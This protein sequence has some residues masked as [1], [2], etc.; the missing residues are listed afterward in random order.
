MRREG[1]IHVLD[2][3]VAR[4]LIER[5]FPSGESHYGLPC[6]LPEN[7]QGGADSRPSM[8]ISVDDSGVSFW[9]CHSC[10]FKATLIDGLNRLNNIHEG[11][12]SDVAEWARASGESAQKVPKL[13]VAKKYVPKD[14]S[15]EL[16]EILETEIPGKAMD[17]L[18][19]KGCK[20]SIANRYKIGWVT[21][22]DFEFHAGVKTLTDIMVF[23]VLTVINEK[24]M[25]VGAQARQIWREGGSKYFT[26]FPF[27]AGRHLFGEQFVSRMRGRDVFIMEGSLDVLYFAGEG[28]PALGALG[29]GL[30]AEKAET[31][32]KTGA[33]AIYVLLDPDQNDKKSGEAAVNK[34]K[35]KMERVYLLKSEAP[36]RTLGRDGIRLLIK[37]KTGGR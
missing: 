26:L 18:K 28:Y 8:T 36:V 27:K 13:K 7:H 23:P 34:I 12:V 9:K 24:V 30:T 6:F 19:S 14:Y 1:V 35:P 32:S 33:R 31:I 11:A 22:R 37:G 20:A 2:N 25:C 10:G 29:T 3:L 21:E 4:G 15:S 5:Y 16:A 17:W